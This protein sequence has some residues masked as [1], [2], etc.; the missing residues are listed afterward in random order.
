ML[1]VK[2]KIGPSKIH[3]IGLFADE[4]IP[5]GTIIW[6]FA[7]DFDL[8]FTEDEIKALPEITQYTIRWYRYI[9]THCGLSILCSDDARFYNCSENPN[10]TGIELDGTEGEGGDITVRDIQ[11]GEEL[12]YNCKGPKEGDADWLWKLSDKKQ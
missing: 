12:T 7:P 3:N 8:K 10:T 2:T 4:F 5:K 6:K 11:V 1:L 9:C